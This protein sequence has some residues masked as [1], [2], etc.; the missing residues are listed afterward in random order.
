[1]SK[2][3]AQQI[4]QASLALIIQQTTSGA[5]FSGNLVSYAESSG[6]F[7]NNVVATTGNQ[8]ITGVKQFFN[9]PLIPYSGN[10]GSAPSA[11]WVNDQIA[12]YSGNADGI[13]VQSGNL[14]SASGQLAYNTYVTGSGLYNLIVNQSGQ[15]ATNY[16]TKTQLFNTGASLSKVRVT[17]GGTVQDA[18]FS[19]L[20]GTLIIH[21][22]STVFISGAAGGGGGAGDSDVQVTG[23]SVLTTANFTGVG[24][25]VVSYDGSLIRISGTAGADATLSGYVE[26]NFVNRSTAQNVTGVKTFV[27]SPIVP[28]ATTETQAINLGQ[29]SGISGVLVERDSTISGVIYGQMTGISGVL[30][31]NAGGVAI[32][33]NYYITGTGVVAASSHASGDINN[34]FSITSG[35]TT[36]INSGTA[37]N[38]YNIN[39]GSTLNFNLGNT[40]TGNLVNI[41]MFMDPVITGLSVGEVFCSMSFNLTGFFLGCVTSGFGPVSGSNA[42]LSG[43]LYTRSFADNSKTILSGF[44]FQSG[45]N[46]Q[47]FGSLT[48]T[49]P[50]YARLGIDITNSL[51]GIQKMTLGFCGV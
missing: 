20:G 28:T 51:S 38:T 8:T 48:H 39:S 9:S 10:T 22:G 18:N 17:G 24:S 35:T 19:G 7:G 47:F 1:M 31:Q 27:S 26:G 43:S 6:W 45:V 46:T 33:N 30:A 50:A 15:A 42:P 41:S 3:N 25:V 32:T 12:A 40:V 44:T 4:D 37:A 2:I 36:V 29:A 23:S 13:F 14:I 11:K 34:T 16:A 5:S 49:V 21:S